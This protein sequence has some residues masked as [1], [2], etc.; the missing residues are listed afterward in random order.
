MPSEAEYQRL[1][2]LPEVNPFPVLRCDD[3][4]RIVY[5]NPAARDVKV[6]HSDQDISD[7]LPPNFP[8]RVR[9]SLSLA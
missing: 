3:A 8:L 1:A 9:R 7:L 2:Q 5:R 4:G 6:G